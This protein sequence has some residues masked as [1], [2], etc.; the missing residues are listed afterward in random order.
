MAAVTLP[1][2]LPRSPRGGRR[3]LAGAA[4]GAAITLAAVVAWLAVQGGGAFTVLSDSMAPTFRAGDLVL[5]ERIDPA[6]AR[7]GDVI[8][9]PSPRD[10]RTIVH[11]AQ[12]VSAASAQVSFVTRGDA[13]PVSERWAVPADG[14]VGRV[15]WVV[16]RLGHVT[17]FAASPAGW[18][19]L[20]AVPGALL[21]AM[22]L[23]RL[24]RR[25]DA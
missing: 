23:R 2:R 7:A 10:G 3:A 8:A 17:R 12:R 13:N 4:A 16:P 20:V 9:F 14:S 25:D 1:V 22:E 19:L 15:R 5:I 6:T 11:R 18:L 21:A 24:R